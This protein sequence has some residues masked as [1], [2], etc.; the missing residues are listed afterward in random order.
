MSVYRI[1]SHRT[2]HL[3]VLQ[4][5]NNILTVFSQTHLVMSLH[6]LGN[7]IPLAVSFDSKACHFT[8]FHD[9]QVIFLLTEHYCWILWRI[10]IVFI[11]TW[12]LI[13]LG[14]LRQPTTAEAPSLVF[15]LSWDSEVKMSKS[16]GLSGHI[17][18][19]TLHVLL[20]LTVDVMW[21]RKNWI[22]GYLLLHNYL[23]Y[24]D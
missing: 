24:L 6:V 8:S 18:S 22:Q 15:L 3:V 14:M 12:F 20:T 1:Y 10:L 23:V 21:G 11:N 13:L 5:H 2:I 7:T 16:V 9:V 17:K 19:S 4:L